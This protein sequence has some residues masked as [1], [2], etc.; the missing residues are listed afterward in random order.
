L[1]RL[2]KA[3]DPSLCYEPN[4]DP[5]NDPSLCYEPNRDPAIELILY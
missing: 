5:A 3:N 1:A 2:I 4:R